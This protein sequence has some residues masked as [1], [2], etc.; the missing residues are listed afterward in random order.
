MTDEA[1][2]SNDF[3][4]KKSSQITCW[5]MI[6]DDHF[7]V[8]QLV[9]VNRKKNHDFVYVKGQGDSSFSSLQ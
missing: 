3:R 5:C 7:V 4:D 8:D 6:C 9:Y 1:V 2:I